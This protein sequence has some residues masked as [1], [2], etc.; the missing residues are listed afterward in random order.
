MTAPLSPGEVLETLRGKLAELKTR[1]A[2]VPRPDGPST[3]DAVLLTVLAEAYLVGLHHGV[4]GRVDPDA[5]S[6]YLVASWYRGFL[7]EMSF[8]LGR[9]PSR[10]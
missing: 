9:E 1:H 7:R 5:V 4:Q 2:E 10:R 6:D 8:R 3:P